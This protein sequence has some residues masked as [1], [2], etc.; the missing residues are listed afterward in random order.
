MRGEGL[1][2][3][4]GQSDPA[5]LRPIATGLR[6]LIKN[7]EAEHR[8]R[9]HDRLDVD[10]RRAARDPARGAPWPGHHRRLQS[11]T[12][13]P[14]AAR[15]RDRRPAAG[16]RP[17]HGARTDHARLLRHVDRAR[18]RLRRP[19]SGGPARPGE[20][21]G[22]PSR[23]PACDASGSRRGRGRLLLRIR[24][25]GALAALP[26]RA[27]TPDVPHFGLGAVRDG[28]PPLRPRGASRRRTPRTPSCSSRT[29][30]SPCCR[31]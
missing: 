3:P 31:A 17:G 20:R 26:Y 14:R 19:R 30:T 24:E 21:A 18:Q 28:Q 23:L 8:S 27:R 11:R 15:R 7:V 25:R 4:A 1:W 6:A 16:E 5:E 10:P 2:R 12:V 22:G 9:D 29:I 13:H